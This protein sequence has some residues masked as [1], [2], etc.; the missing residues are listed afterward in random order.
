MLVNFSFFSFVGKQRHFISPLELIV[1]E[2]QQLHMKGKTDIKVM[3]NVCMRVFSL[4][5]L[6][7]IIQA[8]CVV[9]QIRETFPILL[10]LVEWALNIFQFGAGCH[11]KTHGLY[12][13]LMMCCQHLVSTDMDELV[14]LT[15]FS[16]HL[17]HP[18]RAS[19]HDEGHHLA[20]DVPKTDLQSLQHRHQRILDSLTLPATFTMPEWASSCSI[21]SPSALEGFYTDV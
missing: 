19:F 17:T 5:M 20:E 7:R 14:L 15:Q 6:K 3:L 11:E 8:W 12:S 16:K 9:E 18:D 2:E 21:P 1:R 10:D 4:G 13:L